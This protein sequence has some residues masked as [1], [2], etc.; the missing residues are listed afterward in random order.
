MHRLL[1]FCALLVL[2]A[3]LSWPAL[4]A[5][6]HATIQWPETNVP[7][8]TRHAD[9][10]RFDSFV[11]PDF[12]FITT[13]LDA[14]GLSTQVPARNLTVRGIVIQ[15]GDS[16]YACFDPD[17]LRYSVA[18]R[19]R[20]MSL[21]TMAQASYHEPNHKSNRLPRVLGSPIVATGIYPGW[22]GAEPVFA[23]PRPPGPNPDDA[24]RGPVS[25]KLGRWQGIYVD[26]PRTL[27]SYRVRGTRV[28]EIPGSVAVGDEVGFTRTIQVDQVQEPLTLVAAEVPGAV[29]ASATEQAIVLSH[30]TSR[31]AVAV[32]DA[33][34]G[35]R[36]RVIEGRFVVLELPAGPAPTTFRI[37]AWSGTADRLDHFYQ[38]LEPQGE[39]DLSILN[40]GSARW[41]RSVLTSVRPAPD[42]S[43]FV[44]DEVELPV[45][46]PWLRNVRAA[47]VDFY[48]DGRMAVVTF[49]G[50]VWIGSPDG[51]GRVRWRRFASG[52]YEPLSLVV[53]DE[54]I[55][56]YGREGIVQL[57]DLNDDGEADYYRNV[58][59]EIVQSSE[60]REWPLSM[61]ARPG[62]G[63]F[64]SKGGAVDT[65]PPTSEPI[66]EGFRAGSRHAGTVMSVSADG[67]RVDV[68]ASGFREPSIGVHPVTG[69]V[70][71]SDQQG[72]FVPA[73]P[74]YSVENA[75][76][77]GVPATAGPAIYLLE[78]APRTEAVPP[79][80][81]IT[82]RDQSTLPDPERPIT[83][84]PH[85]VDPS[86][87]GQLWVTSNS[88]GPLSGRMLHFSYA[89]PGTFVVYVDSASAELQGGVIALPG[90]P[91]V[92]LL[93]GAIHPIDGTVYAAG[94]KIW[95]TRADEISSIVRLRY[96]GLP[97]SMPIRV[98]AGRQGILLQFDQPLGT[99]SAAD[100]RKYSVR[101]WNYLRSPSYGSGHYRLDGSEGEEELPIA[102]AHLSPDGRSLLLVV[103]DMR[104]VMQL[105]VSYAVTTAGDQL[106][107]DDVYLTVNSVR[108]LG[109]AAFGL[110]DVD[111]R[112]EARNAHNAS[113]VASSRPVPASPERGRHLVHELACVGCHGTDATPSPGPGPSW[114]GLYGS[115]RHL[116][117]G[118]TVVADEAYLTRSIL[119]PAAE[120]VAGFDPGMP[121]YRGILGEGDL[122]S[123]VSFIRSLS[124][125]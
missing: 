80:P 57:H 67:R 6:E 15:L 71:A 13:M 29:V 46:N 1:I 84:I 94:F 87:A 77:Y 101:R 27:L 10:T 28:L 5:H 107:T 97:A 61:E 99:V 79:S 119:D 91:S 83:W 70:T 9:S 24:G 108:E 42:T 66:M 14:G 33:P 26:G 74:I 44:F 37:T 19:G 85:N 47:D 18:W 115:V 55:F 56:V 98:L 11:E 75:R 106:I 16:T 111:W 3:G 88:M 39:I 43:A 65:G 4:P 25:E 54:E 36:L 114:S 78:H 92:P 45:P 86:G 72:N 100:L 76:Y 20:F 31:T 62:G 41:P 113:P 104:P 53:V 52:L 109:L 95:G 30:G 81:Q 125:E 40:G 60:S 112:Q 21:T 96:T 105:R 110:D 51:N 38:M 68:V 34:E 23:D 102:G 118:T 90:A 82:F 69:A 48:T 12:P 122:E 8:R 73:T 123:I 124:D 116:A 103:P 89:R 117:D 22:L 120:I 63:F 121:S 50:D 64:V 7:E 35:S 2:I 59:N 58:S 93:K 17:L 49:E 32:A